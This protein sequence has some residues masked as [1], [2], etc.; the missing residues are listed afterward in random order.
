MVLH[1]HSRIFFSNVVLKWELLKYQV[2]NSNSRT[3]SNKSNY[4]V[5]S[6]C[7]GSNSKTFAPL[8]AIKVFSISSK[9]AAKSVPIRFRFSGLKI[10]IRV[11]QSN[12]HHP[13]SKKC[14]VA[15]MKHCAAN[16]T[17]KFN[18]ISH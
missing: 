14:S 3:N 12:L 2:Q 8:R 1:F 4:F 18:H 11:N 10:K 17:P 13:R 7:S 16:L 6:L 5:C 9:S 15:V